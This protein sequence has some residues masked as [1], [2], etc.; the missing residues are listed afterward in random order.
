[1]SEFTLYDLICIRYSFCINRDS[2]FFKEQ[3]IFSFATDIY[4]NIEYYEDI[5]AFHLPLIVPFL[6]SKGQ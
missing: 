2:R 3:A 5:Y 6:K 4:P 1:M